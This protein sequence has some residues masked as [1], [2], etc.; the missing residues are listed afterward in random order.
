MHK[1][2][3]NNITGEM[4]ENPSP[5]SLNYW[6]CSSLPNHNYVCRN[7][8]EGPNDGITNFDNFGLSMLTVFQCITNEGKLFFFS[9]LNLLLC[10]HLHIV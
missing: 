7:G 1:T 6:N 4:Y 8:W 5:C 3:Y 9:F 2:C 10:K